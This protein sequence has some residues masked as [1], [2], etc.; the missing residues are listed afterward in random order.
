[1]PPSGTL[2]PPAPE[3]SARG[4]HHGNLRHALVA[5]GL[6]LLEEC[7]LPQLSLRGIAAR[8][9]VSHAA[10]KN[11]FGNRR[12]LQSAM[13]AEGYRLCVAGMRQRMAQAAQNQPHAP[14]TL[15]QLEAIARGYVEFAQAYPQLFM[16]MYSKQHCDFEQP[17]LAEHADSSY[18]LLRQVSASVLGLP[19]QAPPSGHGSAAVCATLV[20]AELLVWSTVHGYAHLM[21]NGMV[22]PGAGPA[23][24][25]GPSLGYCPTITEVAR[26][27]HHELQRLGSTLQPQWAVPTLSV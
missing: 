11:H 26:H 1:M 24:H 19:L 21:L 15:R 13:A 20:Q 8:V 4:Y 16:L 7:G 9:G 10:P 25:V 17:D 5:Q 22:E 12:G 14:E 18:A 6:L 23:S 3:T 2:T 27:L